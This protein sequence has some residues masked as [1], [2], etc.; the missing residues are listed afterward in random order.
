MYMIKSFKGERGSGWGGGS[1]EG[2]L[3]SGGVGH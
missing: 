2:C 3:K 1:S